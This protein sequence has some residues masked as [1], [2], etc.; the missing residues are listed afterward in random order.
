MASLPMVGAAPNLQQWYNAL[1]WLNAQP[2]FVDL[3][4]YLV[5]EF[6]ETFTQPCRSHSG[7][8]NAWRPPEPGFN[9]ST[10]LLLQCAPG[11]ASTKFVQL[12]SLPF[13]WVVQYH[14][15][16]SG[17]SS[18]PFHRKID[19]TWAD[20]LPPE[21]KDRAL[22]DGKGGCCCCGDDAFGIEPNWAAAAGTVGGG[23]EVS[24]P[25]SLVAVLAVG[26]S[27]CLS[28]SPTLRR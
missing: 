23:G 18:S 8:T 28:R 24:P 5:S 25:N 19:P 14:R 22:R 11:S 4:V 2:N 7:G 10:F 27:P 9:P 21:E 26:I 1:V 17:W 6:V 3:Y 15:D 16:S 13:G 12:V 20:L